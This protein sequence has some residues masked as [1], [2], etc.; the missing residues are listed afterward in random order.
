[1]SFSWLKKNV[2]KKVK[3]EIRLSN[4]IS[5][6]FTSIIK[7]TNNIHRRLYSSIKKSI[8]KKRLES[9]DLA[10]TSLFN[11]DA[12]NIAIN[13]NKVLNDNNEENKNDEKVISNTNDSKPS[14][15]TVRNILLDINKNDK[16]QA[17]NQ[18]N[19]ESKKRQKKSFISNNPKQIKLNGK[20]YNF[21]TTMNKKFFLPSKMKEK[22]TNVPNP[23]KDV[24]DHTRTDN[25]FNLLNIN[26]PN[27][28]HV[29]KYTNLTYRPN[30]YYNLQKAQYHNNRNIIKSISF[31]YKDN[32]QFPY[33]KIQTSDSSF[34]EK[35]NINLNFNTNIHYISIIERERKKRNPKSENLP[36]ISVPNILYLFIYLEKIF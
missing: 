15:K 6:R 26:I 27:K 33:N 31:D 14:H 36:D 4:R 34:N 19:N 10:N 30:N 12:K 8:E 18:K 20:I 13:L 17:I 28:P 1:M 3:D 2:S 16:K 29:K 22:T 32:S 7:R 11:T 21:K 24:I 5:S 9:N 23:K 25:N 35:K